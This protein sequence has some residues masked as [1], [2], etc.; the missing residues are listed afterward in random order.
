[1]VVTKAD[2][3]FRHKTH[4]HPAEFT[5]L[6][7][8]QNHGYT[9]K[10]EL[11]LHPDSGLLEL[12]THDSVATHIVLISRDVATISPSVSQSNQHSV[13]TADTTSDAVQSSRAFMSSSRIVTWQLASSVFCR[14]SVQ[15]HIPLKKD[16]YVQLCCLNNHHTKIKEA[17]VA[18]MWMNQY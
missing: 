17:E 10:T 7:H 1:M 12:L 3:K 13:N 11:E 16:N 15:I 14:L 5:F 9:H 18:S 2:W 8:T 6:K 4:K